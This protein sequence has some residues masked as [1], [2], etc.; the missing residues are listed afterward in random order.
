MPHDGRFN[1]TYCVSDGRNEG[2][3]LILSL[4]WSI[5][6]DVSSTFGRSGASGGRIPELS[7]ADKASASA[8][9]GGELA[10]TGG[11]CREI[12]N[13]PIAPW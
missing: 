10:E 7:A 5:D 11:H 1:L 6:V 9:E 2:G 4:G 13:F 3:G 12:N 8:V